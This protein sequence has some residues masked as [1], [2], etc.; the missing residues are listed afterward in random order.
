MFAGVI[1]SSLQAGAKSGLASFLPEPKAG[2]GKSIVLVPP[3]VQSRIQ[4][5]RNATKHKK[6]N[7]LS[8]STQPQVTNAKEELDDEG[9][10][11][12]FSYLDTKQTEEHVSTLRVGPSLPQRSSQ[13][14]L[15][16]FEDGSSTDTV[17]QSDQEQVATRGEERLTEGIDGNSSAQLDP[18]TVSLCVRMCVCCVCDTVCV[19]LNHP[20]CF[21]LCVI[22]SMLWTIQV[23]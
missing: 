10:G 23:S 2:K 19:C 6:A 11:N 3:N 9:T 7:F 12:F 16:H 4:A 8:S 21:T 5:A 22:T 17:A 15:Y 14:N 20:F 18:E 1:K 13:S